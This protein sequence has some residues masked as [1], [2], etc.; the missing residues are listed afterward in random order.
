VM[1]ATS[2]L[3]GSDGVIAKLEG[4]YSVLMISLIIGEQKLIKLI[5]HGRTDS[6]ERKAIE[7]L[8]LRPSQGFLPNMG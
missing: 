7:K 3:L 4:S 5:G 1:V 6:A 8:S 2:L